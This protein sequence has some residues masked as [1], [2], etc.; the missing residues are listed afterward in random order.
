MGI[1][2]FSPNYRLTVKGEKGGFKML[3]FEYYLF[4]GNSMKK[5]EIEL[6]HKE[7]SEVFNRTLKIPS[8][9]KVVSTILNLYLDELENKKIEL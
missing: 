5:E 2:I 4:E 1:L 9:S 7:I 3:D 8:S 6:I